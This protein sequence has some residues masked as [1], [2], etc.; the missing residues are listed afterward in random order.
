MNPTNDNLLNPPLNAEF[1]IHVHRLDNPLTANCHR[2]VFFLQP[3]ARGDN[4]VYI[5]ERRGIGKDAFVQLQRIMVV[6]A[7]PT[8]DCTP[9]SVETL[10]WVPAENARALWNYLVLVGWR[11]APGQMIAVWDP[12][13]DYID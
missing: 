4:M 1:P 7:K 8:G 12:A 11:V 5:E 13:F 9:I 2:F 3:E 6:A 10:K